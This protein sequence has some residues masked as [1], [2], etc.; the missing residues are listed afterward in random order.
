ML[1]Q[2]ILFRMQFSVPGWRCQLPHSFIIQK[3]VYFSFL[4]LFKCKCWIIIKKFSKNTLIFFLRASISF[5][6]VTF[7]RM[8]RRKWSNVLCREAMF[9]SLQTKGEGRQPFWWWLAWVLIFFIIVIKLW[10]SFQ[11]SRRHPLHWWHQCDRLA[12]SPLVSNISRKG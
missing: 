2:Y 10:R 12:P 5:W 6:R 8:E 1:L 7:F 3:W 4:C 9:L 11:S